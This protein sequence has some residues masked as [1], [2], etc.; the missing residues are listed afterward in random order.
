MSATA[1]KTNTKKDPSMYENIKANMTPRKVGE[2]I[3]E[4]TVRVAVGGAVIYA[5]NKG[6]QAFKTKLDA[7]K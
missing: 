3:L 7:R 6:V 5:G 1:R 4:S 2:F